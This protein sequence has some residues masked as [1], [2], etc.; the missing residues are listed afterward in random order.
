MSTINDILNGLEATMRYHLD[1]YNLQ[2]QYSREYIK[3]ADKLEAIEESRVHLH[4]YAQAE[5]TYYDI[6]NRGEH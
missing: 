4:N 2:V 1:N 6:I 5:R 3:R